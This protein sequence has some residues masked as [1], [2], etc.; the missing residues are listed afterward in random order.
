MEIKVRNLNKKE[1]YACKPKDIKKIFTQ[2]DNLFISFGFLYRNHHFDTKFIK[3]PCIN[4]NIISSLQVNRRLKTA[5]LNPILSF[6]VI[7]DDRYNDKYAEIFGES[8]LPKINEWYHQILSKSEYYIP[9]IE[10]LLV[11]WTGDNFKL[12][13]CRYA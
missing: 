2:E 11:E 8:I 7:K 10:V 6:Y 1:C 12:H 4:G 13:F 3:R 9:G 5:D